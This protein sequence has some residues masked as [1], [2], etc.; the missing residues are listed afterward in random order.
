[1]VFKFFKKSG[2]E[3]IVSVSL[4]VRLFQRRGPREDIA[5]FL[6]LKYI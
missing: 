5:N 2:V 6:A 4:S 1:M 3:V